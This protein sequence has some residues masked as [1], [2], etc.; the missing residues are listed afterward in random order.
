MAKDR[1]CIKKQLEKKSICHSLQNHI[2]PIISAAC[3]H[4]DI[5]NSFSWNKDSNKR[6]L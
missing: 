4:H 2:L 3:H 6:L 1:S 5:F